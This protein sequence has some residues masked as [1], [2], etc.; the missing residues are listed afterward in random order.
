M[1]LKAGETA[2][3]RVGARADTIWS[4]SVARP[5]DLQVRAF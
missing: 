1:L 4:A 3:A 2:E 5:A